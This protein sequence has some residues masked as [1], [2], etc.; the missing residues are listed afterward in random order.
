[1][2]FKFALPTVVVA[3]MLHAFTGVAAVPQGGPITLLCGGAEDFTTGGSS[4]LCCFNTGEW[5]C[6]E[7]GLE[8]SV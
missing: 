4:K 7:S 1:M 5:A 6:Q 2:L 3:L 8:C